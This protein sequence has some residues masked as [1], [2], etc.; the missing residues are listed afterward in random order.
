MRALHSIPGI[1]WQDRVTNLEVVDSA[2]STS[3]ESMLLKAQLR[4]VGHVIRVE[5]HRMPRHL[6][7]GELEEAASKRPQWRSRT[8]KAVENFEDTRRQ[9]LTAARDQRHRTPAA[10]VTTTEFQCPRCSRLCVSRL[11]L[12]SHIRMHR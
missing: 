7:C 5:E 9:K 4:W 10:A 12:Q 2:H 11:G 3:V 1:R 8:H 6:P